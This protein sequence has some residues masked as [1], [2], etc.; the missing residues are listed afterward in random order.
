MDLLSSVLFLSPFFPCL[1]EFCVTEVRFSLDFSL[2][3]C[4]PGVC[5]N[6]GTWEKDRCICLPGFSGDHC[7][8]LD[9]RC[10]NGGSWNGIRC[11]CP[12]TFQGSFCE[13]P[14]EQLEIGE[15]PEPRAPV[16]SLEKPCA[17]CSPL[18]HPLLTSLPC[19]LLLHIHTPFTLNLRQSSPTFFEL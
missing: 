19:P 14:V 3:L 2:Y 18:S 15:W 1:L 16:S 7:Q 8:D 4:F 17:L 11:V 6:G 5:D 10:Q 13:L 9:N 12:S